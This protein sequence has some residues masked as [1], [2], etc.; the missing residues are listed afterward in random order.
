MM[1]TVWGSL[2]LQMNLVSFPSSFCCL[3]FLPWYSGYN[4]LWLFLFQSMVYRQSAIRGKK[5]I[6]FGHGSLFFLL[7]IPSLPF[8]I[9]GGGSKYMFCFGFLGG[10]SIIIA[11]L[12]ILLP[13]DGIDMFYAQ[14]YIF[15]LFSFLRWICICF[16]LFS[17][18]LYRFESLF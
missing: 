2:P 8:F 7:F 3:F 17:N 12:K 14:R 16:V 1:R 9:V 13:S 10:R 11:A 4:F 18:L 5:D 6:T 15:V